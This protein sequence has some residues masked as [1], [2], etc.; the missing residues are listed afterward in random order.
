MDSQQTLKSLHDDIIDD[1]LYLQDL[2]SLKLE[3]VNFI[4]TNSLFYYTILPLLCGSLVS[5]QTPR[6]AISVCL[7]IT[8][9]LIYYIRD[10]AFLNIFFTVLFS[11]QIYKGLKPYIEDYPNNPRNYFYD[12]DVQKSSSYSSFV[13]YVSTNFSD[14]FVRSLVYQTN[15]IYP[16]ILA[17]SKKYQKQQEYSN[18]M[19][20]FEN[21]L[22]DVL[23]KF[24]NSELDVM[25]SYHKNISVATGTN[26][27]LAIQDN[28]Q[29]SFL[30]TLKIMFEDLAVKIILTA[31]LLI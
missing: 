13:N 24:S 19:E 28:S 16:E 18:T 6:I 9:T 23:S 17:V 26:I 4:L 1:I 10:E 21:L 31:I 25:T 3:K 12:W 29:F 15:S 2:F 5:M 22:S 20:Y 14:A 8:V 27:G 7:Y 30:K 11:K